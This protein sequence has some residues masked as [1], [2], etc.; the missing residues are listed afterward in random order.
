MTFEID[1]N[2]DAELVSGRKRSERGWFR[3]M[4]LLASVWHTEHDLQRLKI[5]VRA[6]KE[7]SSLR[8]ALWQCWNLPNFDG[9]LR[10]ICHPLKA[11][12]RVKEVVIE[13]DVRTS[14]ANELKFC[15]KAAPGPEHIGVFKATIAQI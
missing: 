14:I 6:R 1:V 8:E 9:Y 15:M 13:G 12:S 11:V 7:P 5:M 4:R 10:Y 3:T 2:R